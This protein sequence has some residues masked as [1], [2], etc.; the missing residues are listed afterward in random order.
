M[1]TVTFEWSYW[2]AAARYGHLDILQWSHTSGFALLDG[3]ICN[4]WYYLQ[5]SSPH[6][7]Q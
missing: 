5:L 2:W 3:T 7:R 1:R 6:P 4:E